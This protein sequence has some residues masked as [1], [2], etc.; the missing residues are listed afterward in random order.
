MVDIS[1][2]TGNGCLRKNDCY[3]FTATADKY[4]QSYFAKPPVKRG[5]ID[6]E[7]FMP[8]TSNNLN[9]IFDDAMK[10]AGFKPIPVGP[11][12]FPF[13]KTKITK[14]EKIVRLRK[15]RDKLWQE[16]CRLP[17]KESFSGLH[18]SEQLNK[19]QQELDK[20]EGNKKSKR[21][22]TEISIEM[23]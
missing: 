23:G 20:L 8:N 4:R 3:R 13:N 15:K 5:G 19:V 17:R 9:K 21:Y 16:F 11:S 10:K 1:M 12:P 7:Y 14:E 22:Y 2:C 18:I 6:C